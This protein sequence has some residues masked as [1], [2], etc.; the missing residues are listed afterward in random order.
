MR[1]IW[2]ELAN[3]VTGV[4]TE[5]RATTTPAQGQ[6]SDWRIGPCGGGQHRPPPRQALQQERIASWPHFPQVQLL[7]PALGYLWLSNLSRPIRVSAPEI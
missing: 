5:Y 2:D 4:T 1:E 3:R 7:S 6:Q